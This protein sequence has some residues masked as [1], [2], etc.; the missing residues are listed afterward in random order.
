MYKHRLKGVFARREDK[1]VYATCEL[2][3]ARDELKTRITIIIQ[4][5]RRIRELVAAVLWYLSK[6]NV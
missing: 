4:H 3:C 6:C 1:E 5:K 2:G